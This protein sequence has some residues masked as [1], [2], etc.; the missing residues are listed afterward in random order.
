MSTFAEWRQDRTK[1]LTV[2]IAGMGVLLFWAAMA[3][4]KL[5]RSRIA[6][7]APGGIAKQ[8]LMETEMASRMYYYSPG[9]KA[10]LAP[11]TVSDTATSLSATGAA[12]SSPLTNRR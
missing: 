3:L 10:K 12:P 11:M 9:A 4:P 6:A 8:G 7:N 2:A 1:V 5:N